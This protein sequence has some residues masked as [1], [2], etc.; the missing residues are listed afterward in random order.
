MTINRPEFVLGAANI[1]FP[2]NI[3]DLRVTVKG[4]QEY[5]AAPESGIA[6]TVKCIVDNLYVPP[7][8][9]RVI[10]FTRVPEDSALRITKILMKRTT[11]HKYVGK[12]VLENS[13]PSGSD[14]EQ[15]LFLQITEVQRLISGNNPMDKN[16][17]R[18]RS[19]GSE[20]MVEGLSLIHI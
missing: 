16:A 6:D 19:I 14:C 13:E 9:T 11:R 2:L 18:V 20:A 5:I 7:D 17:I 8:R 1:H 12:Y 3:W 10:L 15:P 4:T